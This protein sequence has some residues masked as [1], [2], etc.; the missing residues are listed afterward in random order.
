MTLIELLITI[1]VLAILAAVAIPNLRSFILSNSLAGTSSEFRSLFTRARLEAINRN[2]FVSVAPLTR[3]G[4]SVIEWSPEFE[5]FVNPAQLANFDAG[6]PV[7]GAGGTDAKRAERLVVGNFPN[8]DTVR[9]TSNFGPNV[10]YGPSGT[11]QVVTNA[12]ITL[13][14]DRTIVTGGN[15]HRLTF[16]RDGRITVEV[17]TINCPN[18]S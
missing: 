6:S 14:V 4:S 12:R 2:T 3:N 13:C 7:I 16:G 17:L 5:L 10:T 1:V 18:P 11:S 9:I 15:A 8:A